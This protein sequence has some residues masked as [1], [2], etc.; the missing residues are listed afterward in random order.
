M[1]LST[2]TGLPHS[3]ETSPPKDPTVAL[4]LGTYGDPMGMGVFYGRGS[5]V[6]AEHACQRA[7]VER[8]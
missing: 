6:P 3:Q 2:D 4:C 7:V 8:M 5:P 1:P